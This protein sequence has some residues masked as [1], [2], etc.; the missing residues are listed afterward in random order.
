[1]SLTADELRYANGTAATGG[2]AAVRYL[3][4]ARG[5]SGGFGVAGS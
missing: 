3:P 5:G 1:M 2:T 4:G